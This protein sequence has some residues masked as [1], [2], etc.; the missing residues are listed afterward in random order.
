M[1]RDD[2]ISARAGDSAGFSTSALAPL[3][4]SQP[5]LEWHARPA[6]EVARALRT[7]LEE[8][9]SADALPPL[10]P[11]AESAAIARAPW[12]IFF[13]QLTGGVILV[14][15]AAAGVML[16]LGH[17]GDTLAIMA[18]VVFSV[19]FGFVTD[20]RAERALEALRNLTSP[21][22][23]VVRDG[24]EH[25][26]PAIDLRPGD[27]VVLSGG[28]ILAADG[29]ITAARDLQIDES[30]LTGESA[31]VTKS[32]ES[33]APETP[34]PERTDRGTPARPS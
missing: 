1:R 17:Y 5:A 2:R 15:L 33:V 14:L 7:D 34:L 3:A 11:G 12:G 4:S 20:F 13:D 19:V 32:S 18:S 30:A 10:M 8:G 29:R 28:Q 25:E 27:L 22:V 31:P 23:P 6:A 24:L 26:V 9:L 16:V 21:T